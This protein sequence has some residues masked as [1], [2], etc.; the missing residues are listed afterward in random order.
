ME[1][2]NLR[3]LCFAKAPRTTKPKSQLILSFRDNVDR[4]FY[5]SEIAKLLRDRRTKNH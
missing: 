5:T 1:V 3:Y 2:E 4:A